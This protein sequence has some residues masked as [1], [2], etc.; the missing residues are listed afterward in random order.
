[1]TFSLKIKCPKLIFGCEMPESSDEI[2]RA[3]LHSIESEVGP[4]FCPVDL[5]GDLCS[6]Q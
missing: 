2:F 3:K 5:I 4:T 6:F 1:M